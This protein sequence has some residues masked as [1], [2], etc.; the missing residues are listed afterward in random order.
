MSSAR[1]PL[2][3]QGAEQLLGS[4]AGVASA[5]VVTDAGGDI[6]EIHILATPDYHPKQVVRNVESALSAGLGIA[7]DRRI[8]SV[9]QIR[10]ARSNGDGGQ[11]PGGGNGNGGAAR[12]VPVASAPSTREPPAPA[13]DE[14]DEPAARLE[15]VRFQSRRDDG[16]C[17]CEV[18]LRDQDAEHVGVGSGPD[19]ESG[20][21]KAAAGAVVD[22]LTR[23][24]PDLELKLDGATTSSARGRQFTV[25]AA[26]TLAGRE[27]VRLVGC[28][29]VTRSPEESAILAT[30]QATNRW[31]G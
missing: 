27:Q 17:V 21:A 11:E 5:H 9:A 7:I 23:A 29:A 26:H 8:V 24:R 30:L 25:V 16:Q 14:P 12:A 3:S 18:V 15:Y 19:T 20:R 10:T 22:A 1:E 4:L 13:D 31:S 28:A 2:S 6:V